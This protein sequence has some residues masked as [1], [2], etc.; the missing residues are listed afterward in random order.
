MPWTDL[1]VFSHLRWAFVWQRPQHLIS[2]L[3]ADQPTFFVEEP[4]ADP[5]VQ[6]P[7]L[8]WA[9]NG[10]VTQVWLAM[11]GPDRHYDFDDPA[12]AGY[13]DLLREFLGP[14]RHRA[15]WIYTPVA[16]ALASAVEP[17]YV[18]Y[19]VM[20]DLASFKDAPRS[21]REQQD[22]LLA[23]ADIVFAGGRSLHQGILDRRPDAHC[24][25]SGVETEHYLP[26]RA[27]RRR[28]ARPVAGYVGV[29]DERLDLE[30][31]GGLASALPDWDVEVV[32][33][34]VKI[35]PVDLPVAPNLRY[36]G[37]RRYD[38]LPAVMA[39]FDVALM[40]FARNDA[41][42]SISPT[43]TLEYMAAGLP[44]VSTS[45]PDV[46]ADYSDVVCIADD[47]EEF[48]AGCRQASAMDAL[49]LDRLTWPTLRRQHWD[50]IVVRMT[51][52]TRRPRVLDLAAVEESV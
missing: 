29:I 15:A 5:D 1:V 28:G 14:A 42:R 2:R 22:V 35:D 17:S 50:S 8:R 49:E 9:Q 52:L 37:S 24:F 6:A 34:V 26:A 31:I 16:T 7:T 20:D 27:A 3:A 30:L 36:P 21:L 10:A 46:V 39:A 44:V 32:G 48:A 33:P 45:V 13:A 23:G 47:V 43:K 25:P 18:V 4:I 19:D 11:P 12:A 51:A 41:T 40:P 38:E